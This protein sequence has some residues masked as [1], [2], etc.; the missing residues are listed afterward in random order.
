MTTPPATQKNVVIAPL[1]P[2]EVPLYQAVRHAAFKGT[3]NRVLYTREPSAATLERIHNGQREDLKKP[4]LFYYL[5]KD[6]ETG[7]VLAG[8]KWE[9]FGV[10]EEKD[11]D[12]KVVKTVVAER[13]WEEVEKGLEISEPYEETDARVWNTLFKMLYDG[14]REIMGTKPYLSMY[15]GCRLSKGKDV[16]WTTVLYTLVA[17]PS[18]QRRGAGSA[19]LK[20]GCAKADALGIETYLEAS[21]MGVPLY[22][23]FGFKKVKAIAFD[24]RDYGQEGELPLTVSV[25]ACRY[26]K[27]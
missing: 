3:V 8:S 2:E 15:L 9:L 26:G 27:G 23:R 21:P 4:T 18:A 16:S 22:E 6:A 13:T 10:K 11:A 25:N 20:W 14:R 5:A 1:T 7:E 19:L 17:H 24:W 12:G